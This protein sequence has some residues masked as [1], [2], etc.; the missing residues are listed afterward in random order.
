MTRIAALALIVFVGGG[1]A[2]KAVPLKG[3][4]APERALPVLA[5]AP[6][7]RKIVFHWDYQENSLNAN[8]DGAIRVASPD[9]ARVDLFLNGGLF[10]GNATLIGNDFRA[11]NRAQVEKVLPPAPMMWAALGRLAIPALPDTVITAEGD[12]LYADVG[13][14]AAWRVTIK[15]NRLMQL[16]RLN[17]GRIAEVVTR[18]AG[19]RLL[20][21][22]PGRRKLWLGITR[23]DEVPAFDASIWGP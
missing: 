22:V 6:G 16:A 12:V 21:E 5:I 4:P 18:D 19:G 13:R 9:S 14:P 15:G 23:D 7:H 17:G 1:C 3:A 8:G 20:Y 11:A 2:P 10:L